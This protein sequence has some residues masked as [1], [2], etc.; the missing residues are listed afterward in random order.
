MIRVL[1]MYPPFLT[2]MLRIYSGYTHILERNS[3][4][5]SPRKLI[6]ILPSLTYLV[7]IL[8]SSTPETREHTKLLDRLSEPS[9]KLILPKKKYHL[10][11]TTPVSSVSEFTVSHSAT[12]SFARRLHALI[13]HL[14]TQL[15]SK[16]SQLWSN[17]Q[18]LS[19]EYHTLHTTM[20][21]SVLEPERGISNVYGTGIA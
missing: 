1:S 9:S 13:L 10:S 3:R 6:F 8:A 20:G 5:S 7:L 12:L 4:S 11:R 17:S 21:P 19:T 16:L 2:S 15:G 14:R 18:L